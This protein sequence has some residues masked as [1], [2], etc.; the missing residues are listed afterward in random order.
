MWKTYAR[1]ALATVEP[2][3]R[4]AERVAMLAVH[5]K[6]VTPLGM[7]GLASSAANALREHLQQSTVPESAPMFSIP[8][9]AEHL[10]AAYRAAGAEVAIEERATHNGEQ[11]RL[12]KI[13]DGVHAATVYLNGDVSASDPSGFKARLT[14][15]LDASLPQAFALSRSPSDVW[16]SEEVA[17]TGY[18]SKQGAAIAACVRPMLGD[19]GRVVLLNGKPGVGKSTMAQEIADLIGG[20]VVL[21]RQGVFAPRDDGHVTSAAPRSG[22][23]A[24]STISPSVIVIDDVD[25]IYLSLPALETFRSVARLVILTANNGEHDDVLDAAIVRPGRIDEV[26]EIVPDR[27]LAAPAPFDRLDAATWAQVREWPI[28]HLNELGRRIEHRGT[29]PE[30]LRIDDLQRR[31]DRKTRS[32]GVLR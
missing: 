4:V 8:I 10:A 5:A 7:F 24:I 16:H 2:Y 21:V 11:G 17:L 31:I 1:K 32:G 22:E 18:S 15:V 27:D 29:N 6:N 25:K 3:T 12:V 26:F 14:A 30:A 20:R 19:G 28:A 23:I 9:G 13:V